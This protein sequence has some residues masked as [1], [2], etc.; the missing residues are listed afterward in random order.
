MIPQNLR[1]AELRFFPK[2]YGDF[3]ISVWRSDYYDGWGMGKH[4]ADETGSKPPE[5]C[6]Q[7]CRGFLASRRI[8][9]FPWLGNRD[10]SDSWQED[11]TCGC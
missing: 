9:F 1:L 7:S 6:V 2:T 5:V 4:T 3:C 8:P 11:P 10:L